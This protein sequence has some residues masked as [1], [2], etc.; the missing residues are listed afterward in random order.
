[1][2]NPRTET[3]GGSGLTRHSNL[4]ALPRGDDQHRHVVRRVGRFVS[5]GR[6]RQ[7]RHGTLNSASRVGLPS[8]NRRP[9]R[10]HPNVPCCAKSLYGEAPC[11]SAVYGKVDEMSPAPCLLPLPLPNP[12]PLTLLPGPPCSLHDLWKTRGR[13]K[14]QQHYRQGSSHCSCLEH[15]FL[16]KSRTAPQMQQEYKR[17]SGTVRVGSPRA[18]RSRDFARCQITHSSHPPNFFTR[19][20]RLLA[21]IVSL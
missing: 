3:R 8:V 1:M 11:G 18:S 7:F 6:R 5:P 2:P 13:R 20:K 10:G 19:H 16:L 14:N 21:Q 12:P 17:S 4:P 9:S 15:C